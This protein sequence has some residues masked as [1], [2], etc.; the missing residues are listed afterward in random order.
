MSCRYSSDSALSPLTELRL[1]LAQ[2][3]ARLRLVNFA[4]EIAQ[5]FAFRFGELG[6]F[7]AA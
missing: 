6:H 3:L 1:Q 2:D 4:G 7:R 5:N